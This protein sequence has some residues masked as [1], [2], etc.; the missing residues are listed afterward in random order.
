MADPAAQAAAQL[1]NIETATG[2]TVVQ[3]T[4]LI[5]SAG[6]EKHGKIVAY[7]KSEHGL[8][9]GNANLLAH[10]VRE[11][12]EGGPAADADLL[13]AQYEG[14]K[15]GLRPI[16][17]RLAEVAN[18]QGTDV[19]QVIQKTGVSFRRKK[20]FA[21]VQAPSSKRIQLGLNLPVDPDDPRVRAVSGMCSHRVDITDLDQ[22]DADVERWINAAYQSAG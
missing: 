15:A 4:D 21:L 12:L 1:K 18:S 22:V 20:Q 5:R 8:T 11:E 13:A 2:K 10:K 16:Y 9:H 3:F 7:L 19:G 6:L 17:K 14:S